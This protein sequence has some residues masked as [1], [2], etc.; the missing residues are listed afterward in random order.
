VTANSPWGDDKALLL[1][2]DLDAHDSFANGTLDRISRAF[3][4]HDCGSPLL[5]LGKARDANR[6][7]CPCTRTVLIDPAATG[8]W[9]VRASAKNVSVA[10]VTKASSQA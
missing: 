4:Q 7:A 2:P 3:F 5:A 9:A 1:V 10:I 8:R 6:I